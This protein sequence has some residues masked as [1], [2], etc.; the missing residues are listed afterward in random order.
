MRATLLSIFVIAVISTAEA[1][2]VTFSNNVFIV[3]NN[4]LFLIGWYCERGDDA[5]LQRAA[6]SGANVIYS[7][8]NG[9]IQNYLPGSAQ[10]PA[11]YNQALKLYLAKASFYHLY[12][13][14]DLCTYDDTSNAYINAVVSDP[15]IRSHSALLGWYLAD[16][17]ETHS[18]L[19][20]TAVRRWHD[21]VKS[22]D[23]SH[24]TFIVFG[25]SSDFPN[26]PTNS[27]Y[28]VL[29]ADEYPCFDANVTPIPSQNLWHTDLMLDMLR[30]RYQTDG[31]NGGNGSTM[32]VAQG[33]N[34]GSS[35]G[36]QF[37][38]PDP[39][40]IKYQWISSLF[41]AQVSG[42]GNSGGILYW[43]MDYTDATLLGNISNFIHFFT[44]N[45]LDRA[46]RGNNENHLLL[47][48]T[49]PNVNVFLRY[50]YDG[51]SDNLYVFAI[52]RSQLDQFAQLSL[53]L[54]K[55]T[56]CT[57]IGVSASYPVNL[58]PLGRGVF[59]LADE[60]SPREAKI[61]KIQG[62]YA[63]PKLHGSTSTNGISMG[64]GTE[65]RNQ[66][67][68]FLLYRNYPNPFNP[69]TLISYDI[70]AFTKVSI[71]VFDVL[72]R[73]IKELLSQ[74]QG[75]GHYSIRFDAS[76]IPSGLYFYRM[77]AGNFTDTR[78]LVVVK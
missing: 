77:E 7:E 62:T 25:S 30:T 42:S 9:V 43:I 36:V 14:V 54:N 44:G 39:I 38:N 21:G 49:S 52:N 19:T 57:A 76:D 69:S 12:V 63:L 51:A 32:F 5:S 67:T 60:F 1:A 73:R 65:E 22:L 24:P 55:Y 64:L 48:N 75:P 70:P 61:Y 56:S 18:Q 26:Y 37:R 2:T 11:N 10:T 72:G 45:Q 8:W 35:G 59:R 15:A 31:M 50:F 33:G 3:D 28:D 71:A 58:T 27:L 16:E 34:N 41:A 6:A 74:F 46:I 53:W 78:T 4:P 66:P 17:P 23:N 29:M 68:K 20:Y 40:E 47:S 13:I